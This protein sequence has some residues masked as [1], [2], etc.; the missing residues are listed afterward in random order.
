MLRWLERLKLRWALRGSQPHAFDLTA[1]TEQHRQMTAD[2][3]FHEAHG[4]AAA[5]RPAPWTSDITTHNTEV[6]LE[7]DAEVIR[8]QQAWVDG[9]Y[10]PRFF[11]DV[12][13][14]TMLGE[15]NWDLEMTLRPGARLDLT[16]DSGVPM[17]DP[18]TLA[19][20]EAA[21]EAGHLGR[22]VDAIERGIGPRDVESL[23]RTYVG[24]R[25]E[26]LAACGGN[27]A[28][29]D[30]VFAKGRQLLEEAKAAADA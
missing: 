28:M 10:T 4:F 23:L 21:R 20:L 6:R 18:V 12:P 15:V 16:C 30:Q 8:R 1:G 14:G 19:D 25:A 9:T 26:V 5:T 29:A 17:Q 3:R 24:S 7:Y 22:E 13:D 27:E 11:N 2:E